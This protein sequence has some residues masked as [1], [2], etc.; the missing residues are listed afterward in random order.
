MT[1]FGFPRPQNR[2]RRP[3]RPDP[4]FLGI[5][6]RKPRKKAKNDQKN[7][8]YYIDQL[9]HTCF[10]QFFTKIF[11]KKNAQKMGVKKVGKKCSPPPP[12]SGV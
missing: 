11:F 9:M 4:P 1:I 7:F 6:G 2:P 8:G 10:R 5:Y 3:R 12:P